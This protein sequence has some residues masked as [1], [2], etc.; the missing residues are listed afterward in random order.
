MSLW[1]WVWVLVHHSLF[2]VP[3]E[4]LEIFCQ[5]QQVASDAVVEAAPCLIQLWV[6]RQGVERSNPILW[7]VLQWYETRHEP[8]HVLG[9][10][11]LGTICR[12]L[13]LE[14]G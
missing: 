13:N 8:L 9:V 6:R 11:V 2:W 12:C 10:S 4:H 14:Q 1:I 3:L 5:A 7:Q